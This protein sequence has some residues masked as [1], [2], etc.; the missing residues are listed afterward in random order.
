MATNLINKYVWLVD[1][2]YR[3]RKISFEDINRRWTDSEL[4]EGVEL[5]KR[6]FHKWR[7][8][9]EEIFGL[10]IENENRGEYRYYIYNEDEVRNSGL[11]SWMI[12]TISV[13]NLLIDSQGVKDRILLEDIPSGQQ[14]LP[15]IIEALKENKVLYMTYKSYWVDEEHTFDIEPYCVK[16]FKHRWYVVARNRYFKQ[17]NIRTYSLDRIRALYKKGE[18]FTMPADF[19]PEEHF[20]GCYGIIAGDGTEIEKVELKVSAGQ[21]NYVRSLPLHSSQRETKTGDDFCVFE[22]R[23]RPTL[24][25]M[26]EIMSRADDVEVLSPQWFRQEVAERVKKMNGFYDKD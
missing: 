12:S 22:Y 18:T 16:L 5:S 11:R 21:A 9:I 17:N 14:F 7:I 10:V 24:D 15:T 25:F 26:Q 3:A 4:S 23:I 8:A 13:S 6:T 20:N 19:Q 1:T 2:I